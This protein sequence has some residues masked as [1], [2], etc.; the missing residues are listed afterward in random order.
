MKTNTFF[1]A[2]L[3]SPFIYANDSVL[4]NFDLDALLAADVQITSAM[5]RTQTASKTAASVYVL[6]NQKIKSSGVTSIAQALT[7]VP[8]MQVRQI[9]ANKWAIGTRSPAGRFTSRLLVMIDGQSI[10]NPAF[11]GVYWEALNIPLY[12]VERIEV[13]KGQGGLLWG[14][15]ATSGVVNIITKH[16]LDT[17]GALGHIE[18]GS[19]LNH[20]VSFRVGDD[21]N[22]TNHSS[23]RIYGSHESSKRSDE[24]TRWSSKDK[25]EKTSFGGRIDLTLNDDSSL[26]IQGDY[27]DI[28]IGQTLQLPSPVT[29]ERMEV[30][31]P[32]KRTDSRLMLRLDNRLSNNSNQMFQASMSRQDGTQVY[33]N[34]EFS[35]FDFDYQFNILS[36][37]TQTN[38]G[39]TYRYNDI[40]FTAS[41]YIQSTGGTESITQ[42]GGFIQTNFMLTPDTLDLI[43]GNKSEHNS[44]T[45][46]EHQPSV[47]LTW[48]PSEEQFIWAS[49]SQGIRIPS[50]T[51]YDYET[52][53]NGVKVKDFL[54]TGDSTLDDMRIRT[55]LKGDQSIE[56]EK[57][58]SSE[59]GYR[60]NHNDW[61]LDLS[62]F[63]TKS[64]NALGVAPSISNT[65]LAAV[66]SFLGGGNILGALGYLST[67]TVDMTFLSGIDLISKGGD[68]V[69]SWQANSRVHSELG[70]SFTTFHYNNEGNSIIA[71][72]GALHQVF[73]SNTLQITDGQ[74][75]W[76]SI[77]WED[78]DSYE[79]DDYV[80]LNLS[81]G[82]EITPQAQLS[83]TGN[84]LLHS[85]NLEYGKTNDTLTVPA[86]IDRSF[87]LRFRLNF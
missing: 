59:V 36:G 5:K 62:L 48:A 68:F 73:F 85:S 80:A 2:F 81:W 87:I 51:E 33:F 19:Y 30:N 60:V 79:T 49:V 45:G 9:D 15:N 24:S 1:Y 84:N 4:T 17:R 56:V 71:D 44:L 76:S 82:W 64:K 58:I 74:T 7:L 31:E 25:A 27:T 10:Y 20:R 8:G 41:D 38:V 46:W 69:I 61:N 14:S 3:F 67:V 53:V 18:T 65:D 22:F 43:L 12:D 26:I 78:G 32:G 23:Y 29:H 35:H 77:R 55:V 54:I 72:D 86:Y 37:S 21:L 52:S 13:I 42:Y 39:L 34:E 57:S 66:S 40:P 50:L 63:Y 11:S 6:S 75:F 16:S 70:Y 28:N 83:L 47:K